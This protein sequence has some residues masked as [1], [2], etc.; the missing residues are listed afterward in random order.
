MLPIFQQKKA[1]GKLNY[2]FNLTNRSYE[3]NMCPNAQSLYEN[4]LIMVEICSYSTNNK[5]IRTLCDILCKIYEN[6][7]D[8]KEYEYK[9]IRK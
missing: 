5:I 4:E 9:E 7:K 1:F 3:Y 6:I 2:P 8:L